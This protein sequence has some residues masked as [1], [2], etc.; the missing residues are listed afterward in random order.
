MRVSFRRLLVEWMR[1]GEKGMELSSKNG[2]IVLIWTLRARA[3]L[4]RQ[5][6]E[7][8]SS[9]VSVDWVCLV[10]AGI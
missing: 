8:L 4:F 5:N 2:V 7:M 6:V 1:S 3:R 9:P 10:N